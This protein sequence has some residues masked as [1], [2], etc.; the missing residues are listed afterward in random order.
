VHDVL[1]VDQALRQET[2]RQH[3]L[4]SAE[5]L[6]AQLGAN[7]SAQTRLPNRRLTGTRFVAHQAQEAGS[8]AAGSTRSN[9]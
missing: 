1:P 8:G 7:P 5:R 3:V 4:V 6:E 2:I 9:G